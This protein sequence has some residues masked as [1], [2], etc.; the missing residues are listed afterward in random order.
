[1]ASNRKANKGIETLLRAQ[2]TQNVTVGTLINVA[3]VTEGR[4]TPRMCWF[5]PAPAFGVCELLIVADDHECGSY[6][7]T[8]L[9]Q[10]YNQT[11]TVLLIKEVTTDSSFPS[12]LPNLKIRVDFLSGDLLAPFRSK[13]RLQ[14][15]KNQ[16][17]ILER[18][19]RTRLIKEYLCVPSVAM[20]YRLLD[21]LIM[22]FFLRC[23][24][25][26]GIMIFSF[27]DFLVPEL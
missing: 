21:G 15:L 17:S 9:A 5:P 1:M 3:H 20:K 7:L 16:S 25:A 26:R 6:Q 11:H 23:F 13:Q 27:L 24:D 18:G 19:K 22:L 14:F 12:W 10:C 8:A 2:I 4:K